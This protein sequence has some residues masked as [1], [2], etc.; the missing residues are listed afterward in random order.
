MPIT[1]TLHKIIEPWLEGSPE[2]LLPPFWDGKEAIKKATNRLSH[3]FNSRFV[4]AKAPDLNFHD[5]R[6][7]AT[8]RFFER[9]R[10]TDTEIASITGHKD[11]RM[12][13]RYANLQGQT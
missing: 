8:S 13:R 5:L 1:S 6:H 12:M 10:L 11:P 9:T 7:E 2:D 3:L 4:K